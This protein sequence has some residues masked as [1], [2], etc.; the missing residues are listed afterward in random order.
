MEY[1]RKTIFKSQDTED[2]TEEELS[3]NDNED[4][5]RNER[6]FLAY[7][8]MDDRE[9]SNEKRKNRRR[10]DVETTRHKSKEC[11]M[12]SK[13]NK[14]F[15]CNNYG[16]ISMNCS[17]KEG[18]N[19]KTRN[20]EEPLVN[21]IQVVPKNGVRLKI[22]N[23]V[24]NYEPEKSK[25]TNI[26]MRIVLKNDEPIYQHPSRLSPTE[27]VEK[28]V[29]EWL[30][31]GIVRP[32][33]SDYTSPIVLLKKKDGS[34]RICSDY[35]KINSHV[36]KN[37][38][39]LPLIEDVIDR[40]QG[41]KV[42]STIDLK[43]SF[44]HVAVEEDTIKYTSFVTHHG[45]AKEYGLGIKVEKCQFLKSRIEFLRLITEDGKELIVSRL[46]QNEIIRMA[47]DN[48]HFA[49]RK[50][51]EM[52]KREFHI[53]KL[54]EKI[55]SC[56]EN[57]IPCISGSRKA[58]KK[59]GYLHPINKLES[60]LNTLHIDH[61][62]PLPSTNKNYQY[63]LAIIDDFSKLTWLYATKSSTTKETIS[64]LSMLQK[65]FG[66][67]TRV[68][69]YKDNLPILIDKLCI[70]FQFKRHKSVFTMGNYTRKEKETNGR[71]RTLSGK[72]KSR[73]NAALKVQARKKKCT[74]PTSKHSHLDKN[75]QPN[76]FGKAESRVA[77][78]TASP[79]CST[80]N[81]VDFGVGN[82]NIDENPP[83]RIQ[84]TPDR[85]ILNDSVENTTETVLIT[86]RRL[87]DI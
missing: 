28:Q 42:Y 35:R 29:D 3:E 77:N 83:D 82:H 53:P 79:G 19:K 5:E 48:G 36:V 66:N 20:T 56:I 14:C 81:D 50:T 26:E 59:E 85:Q 41:A 4:V 46:M 34:V 23:L 33:C 68:V 13:G 47:H 17:K 61:L 21:I 51:E 86:G 38:F 80:W 75:E 2:E 8:E 72:R 45:L 22:N 84:T 1:N 65:S 27:K 74:R 44:L 62:G 73:K 6:N 9:S 30:E 52:V 10:N 12:K 67:P 37:R 58:G 11:A 69:A 16:H 31:K 78:G 24:E 70:V 76:S 25:T 43:S 57:C 15:V 55:E 64:C 18:T 49:T 63:I 54:R 60:R 87:F 7:D 39:P 40:L 32:S 71:T